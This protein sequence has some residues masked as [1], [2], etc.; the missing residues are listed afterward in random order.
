L[1]SM[2]ESHAKGTVAARWQQFLLSAMP[3]GPSEQSLDRTWVVVSLVVGAATVLSTWS[4]Y[5]TALDVVNAVVGTVACL[6]LAARRTHPLAVALLTVS[7]IAVSTMA[8]P[9]TILAV[10]NLALFRTLRTYALIAGCLVAAIAVNVALYPVHG[11]YLSGL[12]TRMLLA[13]GVIGLG[14]LARS[15]RQKLESDLKHRVDDARTAER[16]RIAREMH[17]VLAHRL[18]LLAV[19]AGALEFH[20]DAEPSEIAHAAGVIRANA[21]AALGELRQVI[22]LL[23]DPL[24]D[25]GAVGVTEAE[26]PQPTL[27]DLSRLVEESREAGMDVAFELTLDHP[28]AVPDSTARAVYRVVQEGLTNARK[29]APASAVEVEVARDDDGALAVSVLSRPP[30]NG[31]APSFT[32]TPAAVEPPLSLPG[33]GT[34]LIGLGERVTLAGGGLTHAPTPDGGYALRAR[35]PLPA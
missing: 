16:A 22:G 20:P 12:P 24:D 27:R 6:S 18:S 28:E 29:H 7:A 1:L 19:Q 23:R 26:R 15:Q 25:G 30:T 8:A 9:A 2:N 34:G 14:L 32:A 33:T 11:D 4:L 3:G 5:G 10:T 35:L 13:A 17:D 31:S 21:H